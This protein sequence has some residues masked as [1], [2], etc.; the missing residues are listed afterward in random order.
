MTVVDL[1]LVVVLGFAAALVV[2]EVRK[3][4]EDGN[5][6]REYLDDL[7]RSQ[8]IRACERRQVDAY[9]GEASKLGLFASQLDEIRSLPE[10]V[11]R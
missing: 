6:I 4:L 8:H 11:E 3:A 1:G 10:R 5:R 9:R 2:V 7:D